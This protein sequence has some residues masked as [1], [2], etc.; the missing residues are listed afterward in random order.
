M[1]CAWLEGWADF[2]AV[3]LF[4]G[5]LDGTTLYSD[6]YF[7]E[8]WFYSHDQFGGLRQ[9]IGQP[10]TNP[11]CDGSTIE[12]AVAAFLYDLVDDASS[13]DHNPGVDDDQLTLNP[14]YVA[15]VVKTCRTRVLA[16]WLWKSP[17][18]IDDAIYCLETTIDPTVSS[19][20]FRTRPLPPVAISE[21]AIEPPGWSAT[22]IRFQWLW[23]LY[24]R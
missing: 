19:E 15:A 5:E 2:F 6:V 24:A 4:G 22:A 8:N 17:D 20:Y 7:E 18:G 11:V 12:G 14:S 13:P 10:L 21:S 3:Y 9:C 16:S 1:T 23:S